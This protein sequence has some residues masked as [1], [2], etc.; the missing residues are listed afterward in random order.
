MKEMKI[1]TP[2]LQYALSELPE[3]YRPLVQAAIHATDQAYAPYSHFQVGAALLLENDRIVTGSN[4]ENAAYPS[5]L[6]AE[7]VALFHAGHQYPDTT[8]LAIAIAAV[9]QG[10]QTDRI[11]PCGA[12]RQVLLET[13]E[14]Q[15]KPIKILFC[16]RDSVWI[17]EGATALLPLC[18]G[19]TD[20]SAPAATEETN[21]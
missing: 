12:C 9:Y 2:V 3:G 6:C 13:E 16:N 17:V 19:S 7:R 20:L 18:F 10:K 21:G 14:R 11:S 1:E 5:G 4:Q 8:V 15:R